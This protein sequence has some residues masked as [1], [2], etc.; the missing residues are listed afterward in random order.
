MS[1]H[2][3]HGNGHSEHASH[4]VTHEVKATAEPLAIDREFKFSFKKQTITDDLGAEVKRPPVSLLIPMPTFSGLLSSLDDAKVVAFVLDL[5]EEAIKDQVRAQLSDND[6][7]VMR[8]EDLDISKLTLLAIANMPNSERTGGGISKET[9][10]EWEKDYIEI[11]VPL[12]GSDPKA[13]EKVA[14]AAKLFAGRFYQC[15]TD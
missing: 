8:Q 5:C 15:R 11:M 12:R 10:E 4:P 7:P 9:W 14:K 3:Q 2:T 13:N 1:E 6:K